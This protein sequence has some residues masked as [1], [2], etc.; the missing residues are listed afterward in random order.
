MFDRLRERGWSEEELAELESKF[1]ARQ[2]G[3]FLLFVFFLLL[4]FAVVG[5]PYAYAVL[6]HLLADALFYLLLVV[7]A[8]P[9]GA[10]FGVLLV[11]MYRLSHKHHV[12]LLVTLPLVCVLSM[13]LAVSYTAVSAPQGAFTHNALISALIYGF[14]FIA[15]YA[16]LIKQEW[17]SRIA[18]GNS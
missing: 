10:V 16:F 18:F 12:W 9:L 1:S 13:Y 2:E 3:G 4:A 15:P 14:S 7:V 5:V 6:G 11:D 8:A 17:N